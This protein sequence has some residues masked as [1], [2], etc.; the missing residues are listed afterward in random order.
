MITKQYKFKYLVLSAIAVCTLI[1]S[2]NKSDEIVYTGVPQASVLLSPVNDQACEIGEV[3]DDRATV[4]FNWS[5]TSE[6]EVY[7]LT[8]TNLITQEINP[9]FNL[10]VTTTTVLLE[11][12]YPY[13]WTITS[14]NT[15]DVVTKSDTWK[16]YLS[17]E[18]E[19][20]FV[21]FP[22]QL[23]S[24]ESGVTVTPEDG[25]ITLEWNESSDADGEDV[26]YTFFMDKIDGKQEPLE[27]WKNLTTNT[28]EVPVDAG[29]VYF[30]HVETTDGNNTALSTTYTFKTE[31]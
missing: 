8:I 29:S 17:G 20:N 5:E 28:I 10:E 2:C 26:T 4:T 11:R 21:P 19:S 6:T 14:K 31:D 15:G 12:G 1:I 22:A 30:W 18:G 13:S 25:I 3:I 16:F 7:D 27:E 24:P 23:I 9:N